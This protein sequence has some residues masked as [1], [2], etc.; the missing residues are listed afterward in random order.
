MRAGFRLQWGAYS[1][2]QKEKNEK[3]NRPEGQTVAT[4]S[5]C[6]AYLA[7]YALSM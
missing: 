7:H 1:V 6:C 2:E 3:K 5:R 4:I